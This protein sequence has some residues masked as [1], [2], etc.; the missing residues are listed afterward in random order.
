MIRAG[1]GHNGQTGL[2]VPTVLAA[3]P[4]SRVSMLFDGENPRM[5]LTILCCLQYSYE[6]VR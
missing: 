5:T 4:D 3:S 6:L 2:D 1:Y